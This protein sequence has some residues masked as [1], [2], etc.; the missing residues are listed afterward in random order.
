MIRRPPRSTLFP[1]TTLF[2]SLMAAAGFPAAD[3]VVAAVVGAAGLPA[4][5][6][7]L[8]AGKTVALANKESL[9]T[10]GPLLRQ[11]ARETGGI[12]LPVDSE[13]SAVPQCLRGAPQHEGR[14]VI[15][16]PSRGPFPAPALEGP[17][18]GSPGQ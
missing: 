1:Y 15:P 16:T 12:L 9:V 10:A 3:I 4:T 14:R 13:H 2:R 11:A 18:T 17:K 8:R 7:A 5:Y 6:H